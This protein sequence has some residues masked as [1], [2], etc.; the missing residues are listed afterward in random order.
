M[1]DV[2]VAK[3]C[4]FFF[5]LGPVL[6][7]CLKQFGLKG[8]AEEKKKKNSIIIIINNN[9]NNMVHPSTINQIHNNNNNTHKSFYIISC[10]KECN[11]MYVLPCFLYVYGVCCVF[12]VFFFVQNLQVIYIIVVAFWVYELFLKNGFTVWLFLL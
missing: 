7:F 4:Y 8:V 9:N 12:L 10:N 2:C 5:V 6:C 1:Y 3:I 11:N